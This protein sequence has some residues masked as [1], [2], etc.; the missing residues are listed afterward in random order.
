[1]FLGAAP[2]GR[3]S[4]CWGLGVPV[5]LVVYVFACVFCRGTKARLVSPA[6]H[7]EAGA[8]QGRR[9]WARAGGGRRCAVAGASWGLW[10]VS[11]H[12]PGGAD[13]GALLEKNLGKGACVLGG[14]G[15]GGD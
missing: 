15:A 10:D 14:E 1:M 13:V 12:L 5:V 2:F 7:L 4:A 9:G 3:R 8:A 11:I 6:D